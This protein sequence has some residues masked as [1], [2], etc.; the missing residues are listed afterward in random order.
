MAEEVVA[1][2]WDRQKLGAT[3]EGGGDWHPNLSVVRR[4]WAVGFSTWGVGGSI[5]RHLSVVMNSGAD[6]FFQY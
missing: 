3:K 4:V 2:N 1:C 5:D 6:S